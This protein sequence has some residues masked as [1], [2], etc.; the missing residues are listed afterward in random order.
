M[1][2]VDSVVFSNAESPGFSSMVNKVFVKPIHKHAAH[3]EGD[4]G[5]CCSIRFAI[6]L[7]LVSPKSHS[8][9]VFQDEGFKIPT[10]RR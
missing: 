3:V 1:R 7:A 10:I 2:I 5:T 9:A 4:T 8:L 6:M